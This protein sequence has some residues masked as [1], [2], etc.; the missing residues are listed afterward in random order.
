MPFKV[1]GILSGELT[2]H[3]LDNIENSPTWNI[4]PQVGDYFKLQYGDIEEEYEIT[5]LFDTVLTNQNGI[6]PLLG[7]YIFQ[8]SA[9]RRRPS[10]E[11]FKEQND[12]TP[13]NDILN[14]LETDAGF[15]KEPEESNLPTFTKEIQC[16]KNEFNKLTN[17]L[18]NN[19]YTY[20]D[21]SDYTYGGYQDYPE[22]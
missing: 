22:N 3:T 13:G 2:Y 16:D 4:A 9:V 6:N 21:K 11:E 7:K 14:E 5:Q 15:N 10:H 19:I 18:A 20:T 17:K 1:S 8:C 12:Y